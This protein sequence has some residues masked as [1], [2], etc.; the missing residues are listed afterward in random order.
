LNSILPT[1]NLAE[2]STENLDVDADK[3]KENHPS[4]TKKLR[5]PTSSRH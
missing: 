1:I 4:T 2:K 3:E 5:R